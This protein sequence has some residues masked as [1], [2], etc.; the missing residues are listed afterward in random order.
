MVLLFL[1]LTATGGALCYAF[2]TNG[3]AA[4]MGRLVFA[5]AFLVLA[6]TFARMPHLLP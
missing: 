5:C 1:V 2:S 6:F 4:E 3:K